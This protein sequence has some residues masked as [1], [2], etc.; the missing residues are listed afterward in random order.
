MAVS[1]LHKDRWAAAAPLDLSGGA[2]VCGGGHS[3]SCTCLS[4]GEEDIDAFYFL[5]Y[6]RVIRSNENLLS[7]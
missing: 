1:A 2:E 7:Y 6:R 3:L 5:F 4:R